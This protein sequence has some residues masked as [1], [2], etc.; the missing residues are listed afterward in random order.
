MQCFVCMI[1]RI[2]GLKQLTL[3]EWSC[4]ISFAWVSLTCSER[5]GREISKWKY[6]SLA[7]LEPPL[8]RHSS[9]DKQRLRPLG[10]GD[11]MVICGLMSYRIPGSW[12]QINKTITWQHVSNWLCL[13]VYIPVPTSKLSFKAQFFAETYFRVFKLFAKITKI[14]FSRKFLVIR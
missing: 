9:T 11:L 14:R 3:G 8:R 7:G 5:K 2:W 12:I 13:H 6:M 4:L 1:N 10:H